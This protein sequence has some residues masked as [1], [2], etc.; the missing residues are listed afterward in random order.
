MD[1]KWGKKRG[2]EF[3]KPLLDEMCHAAPLK[4]PSMTEVV[5]RF[6]EIVKG[7]S[8]WKLRSRVIRDDEL[9]IV[10]VTT[11]PAHWARQVSRIVRRIPA[12]PTA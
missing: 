5:A 2:L 3:M 7:L 4:R 10:T 8:G 9:L 12:I 6:A 1:K 11:A